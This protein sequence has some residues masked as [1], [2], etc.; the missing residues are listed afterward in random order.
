MNVGGKLKGQ[1]GWE[2]IG[3]ENMD[4]HPL[5]RFS[6]R[7]LDFGQLERNIRQKCYGHFLSIQSYIMIRM[8]VRLE[9]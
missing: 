4:G 1:L 3:L 9:P 2:M 8:T 5:G 6:N 7:E